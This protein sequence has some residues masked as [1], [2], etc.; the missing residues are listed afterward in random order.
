MEGET[1]SHILITH[2]HRDHS[3]AAAPL[4]TTGAPTYGYGPHGGDP[5]ALAK[6]AGIMNVPDQVIKDDV[7]G[8]R[9]E[10]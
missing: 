4:K 9:L 10:L 5:V 2:T 3:P 6:K 8:E 7:I 1:V